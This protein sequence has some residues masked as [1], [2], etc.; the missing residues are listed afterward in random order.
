MCCRT[1]EV[2][3]DGNQVYPNELWRVVS[4][5]ALNLDALPEVWNFYRNHFGKVMAR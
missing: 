5:M 1:M 4:F 3:L 2:M